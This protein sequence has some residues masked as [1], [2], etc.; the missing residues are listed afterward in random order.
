MGRRFFG[1]DGVRGVANS[2]PITPEMVMQLAMAAARHICCGKGNHSAVIGKDTRLSGYMLEPSLTAGFTSMG[3]DVTM[4]GPMP[5]PAVAMLTRSLR[6]DIGVVISASHNPH[7][8]NGIKLFGSD[9]YKLSDKDELAI[10]ATMADSSKGLAAPEAL[11]RARRLD[12]APGRYIEF[13]KQTFPKGSR[14]DGLRIVVDCANGAAYK[15]APS[16][17]WELGADVVPV[18]ISPDGTNINKGLGA[19]DPSYMCDHVREKK[20]DIG[21]ALDGDADRVIIANEKGVILDGDQLMAIIAESLQSQGRLCGG[22]IVATV[23]SNLGLERFL[24]GLGLTLI[25]TAVGDRYVV[26][27]MRKRDLNVGGEQSGHIILRDYVTTGD[28]LIAA[29]QVLAVLVRKNK[30]LSD[31]GHAFEPVPQKLENIKCSGIF[32]L[33]DELVQ[34]A[35][36]DGE[37]QLGRGGRLVIRSSGTEP[38]VRVMA[39][40]DNEELIC[41]VVNNV[42]AIIKKAAS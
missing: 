7:Q 19:T 22:G 25:R 6:A 39:Q 38:V 30:S 14:L 28:A 27:E 12:D 35:I 3:V 15:V 32:S 23:M 29:L 10:E 8:Y 20:A 36:R 4:V 2:E 33:N 37:T 11:G 1:T 17:F 42:S 24:D 34:K 21:I 5:T 26:E 9:G 40:G 16:V 41:K 18:G 13:V 31:I